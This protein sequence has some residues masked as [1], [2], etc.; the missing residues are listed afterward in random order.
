MNTSPVQSSSSV[1]ICS[2]IIPCIP[3]QITASFIPA[4]A[5]LSAVATR[6]GLCKPLPSIFLLGSKETGARAGLRTLSLVLTS[7]PGD[8][9]F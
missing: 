5:R 2:A 7:R 6:I 4:I 9:L 3:A 1:F 8:T